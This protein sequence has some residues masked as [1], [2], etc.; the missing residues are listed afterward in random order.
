MS[1]ITQ[2]QPITVLKEQGQT[3][4][5]YTKTSVP[6][7]SVFYIKANSVNLHYKL[8]TLFYKYMARNTSLPYKTHLHFIQLHNENVLMCRYNSSP[9]LKQHLIHTE[10]LMAVWHHNVGLLANVSSLWKKGQMADPFSP[11]VLD[12]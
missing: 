3:E 6:Q 4:N 12:Y 5:V 8:Y 2:Y 9:L 7:F 1:V 10:C 11:A